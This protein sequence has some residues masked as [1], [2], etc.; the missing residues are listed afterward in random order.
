MILILLR[1]PF[2]V[3]CPKRTVTSAIKKAT[4]SNLRVNY[5]FRFRKSTSDKIRSSLSMALAQKKA[6]EQF[7]S[8]YLEN[9]AIGL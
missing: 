8:Y 3:D 4:D 2:K 6:H 5:G 9:L 1:I 7:L